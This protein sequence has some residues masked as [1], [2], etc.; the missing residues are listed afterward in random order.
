MSAESSFGCLDQTITVSAAGSKAA[1]KCAPN[2]GVLLVQNN[3]PF[4]GVGTEFQVGDVAEEGIKGWDD[5]V[6]CFMGPQVLPNTGTFGPT[7]VGENLTTEDS[8]LHSLPINFRHPRAIQLQPVNSMKVNKGHLRAVMVDKCCPEIL[9]MRQV[10]NNL[11][12]RSET[13]LQT[14]R[15]KTNFITLQRHYTVQGS[16]AHPVPESGDRK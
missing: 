7:E 12:V 16:K 9:H 3:Q 8:A 2:C 15:S 11:L 5:A 6:T 1:D 4:H 14:A 10:V 13:R